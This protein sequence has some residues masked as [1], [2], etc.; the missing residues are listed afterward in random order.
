MRCSAKNNVCRDYLE[1]MCSA[2]T[3]I[4]RPIRASV[5]LKIILLLYIFFVRRR[6]YRN[7]NYTD[8]SVAQWIGEDPPLSKYIYVITKR[9]VFG[10]IRVTYTNVM[11]ISLCAQGVLTCVYVNVLQI[12]IFYTYAHILFQNI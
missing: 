8:R 12:D 4:F 5:W 2:H 7:R 11:R 1:Y 3:R 10:C 6:P 9:F